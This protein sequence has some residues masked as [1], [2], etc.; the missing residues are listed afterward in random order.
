MEAYDELRKQLL[1][2]DEGVDLPEYRKWQD[3]IKKAVVDSNAVAQETGLNCVLVWVEQAGSA[4][5]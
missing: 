1:T 2:L 4:S 3:A 5:K